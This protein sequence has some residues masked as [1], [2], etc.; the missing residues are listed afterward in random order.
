M[1]GGPGAAA[2]PAV[3]VVI[4]L[5]EG[6]GF[7]DR[8]IA[9]VLRQEGVSLELVVRDDGSRDDSFGAAR[10]AVGP[11]PRARVDRTSENLGIARTVNGAVR[12]VRGEW[13]LIL[14]QDCELLGRDALARAVPEDS[15]GGPVWLVG[16]PVIDPARL[17][18]AERWFWIIRNHLYSTT[19]GDVRTG[20]LDLFS[21]NKCDLIRKDVFETLGGFD[22]SIV[23]GGEDQVLAAHARRR[24]VQALP[25]PGL[26]FAISLGA[27]SS[28]RTNLG[29]EF[30]YGHQVK[31]VL[32]RV[33]P[34]YADRGTGAARDARWLN[35]V[36]GLLWILATVALV[37]LF[38]V[39][40]PGLLPFAVVPAFMRAGLFEARAYRVRRAY[41]L[42][43]ADLGVLPWVGLIADLWYAAGLLTPIRARAE[44]RGAASKR[45]LGAPATSREPPNA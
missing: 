31:Q 25:A 19:A 26:R 11:D 27:A 42:R 29:K 1:N 8:A 28:V 37:A 43:G 45:D 14:H 22:E 20:R 10:R 23:G 32:R 40:V 17:S 36:E 18:R 38:A 7:V 13:V 9:S 21:E 15:V 5:H 39:V 2:P 12:T 16:T 41:L 35:R 34:D 4:P 24:G 44:G 6:A 30:R 33:G 3:S